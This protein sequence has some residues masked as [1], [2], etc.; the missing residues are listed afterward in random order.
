MQRRRL[1][2]A[3]A[4]TPGSALP[5]FA[6]PDPTAGLRRWGSGEFRRFG[7]LI[8]RATLWAGDEPTAPPLA[9]RLD[10]QRNLD[11]R[12]IADASVK[13]MRRLGVPEATLSRWGERMAAI[14]PD[15]R[16]GDYITG[17]YRPEGVVFLFNDR[18]IGEIA[19]AEFGRRFFGIW[20]DVRTS[21]PEL[22]AVLLKREAA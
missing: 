22:R 21:A 11:G 16:V 15:V 9:L 13:E 14:F 2:L 8:Y 4:A 19:E 1:L 18:V 10:Y 17:I 12:A 7:F 20:L 5:A 6:A 3:M